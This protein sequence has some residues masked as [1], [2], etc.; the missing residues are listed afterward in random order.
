MMEK[1]ER[2]Q[3]NGSWSKLVRMIND[4]YYYYNSVMIFS[5]SRLQ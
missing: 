5:S 3:L 2:V 1:I 4:R